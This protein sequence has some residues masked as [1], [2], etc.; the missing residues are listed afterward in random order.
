MKFLANPVLVA[1]YLGFILYT[2]FHSASDIVSNCS[3]NRTEFVL[4]PHHMLGI[5]GG[6]AVQVRAVFNTA[7]L[8]CHHP[9]FKKT[10]AIILSQLCV[11]NKTFFFY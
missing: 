11:K 3:S 8:L 4:F 10:Q 9:S 5:I 1:L 7:V 2:A 6:G